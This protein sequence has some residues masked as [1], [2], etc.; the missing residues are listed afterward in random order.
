MLFLGGDIHGRTL[1]IV[2]AGRIGTAVALRSRGFNM[3]VLYCSDEQNPLIEKEVSAA[4]VSLEELLK[5]SDFVSL[6]V[7]LTGRTRHLVGEGELRLMK[8]SA[9]LINTSRGAVVDEEALVRVLKKRGIAGAG[10]DVYEDEPDLK[11]GLKELPNTVLLPHIGSAS[12]ET[13]GR[14]ASMAAENLVCMLRGEG[15]LNPVNAGI[16]SRGSG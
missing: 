10:L 14:M 6:H 9:C 3:N 11:P 7:P 1:G 2:G 5:Q 12:P 13:R 16:D 4:R 15:P 8:P